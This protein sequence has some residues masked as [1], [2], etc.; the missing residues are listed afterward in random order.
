MERDTSLDWLSDLN[1]ANPL[2]T[3]MTPKY[4]PLDGSRG[5]ALVAA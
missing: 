4:L 1:Y 5:K 3:T 2:V